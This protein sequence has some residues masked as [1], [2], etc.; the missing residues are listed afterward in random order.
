MRFTPLP[1]SGAFRIDLEPRGDER[2]FFSRI[3][4]AEEFSSHGLAEHWA[5]CNIS[6][7]AKKGTIRGLHFQRPP[8][9]ETKL[10]RCTRGAIFD[11][12]VD[13]R[14]GSPTYGKWHSEML[15]DT[16]RAMICVPEGFAHGLQTLTDDVEILYFV[17]AS[18]CAD[19]EGGLRWNDPTLGV[20]W[21]LSVS[22]ISARDRT[23]PYLDEMEP[24]A[25]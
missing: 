23:L 14:L 15:D 5:Q 16:N 10:V 9:A 6:F 12:I 13:L 25:L 18:Y 19:D 20:P 7:S 21:P 4:C 24:I 1:L 2:G 11:V 3:F 22:D 17:S 8:S